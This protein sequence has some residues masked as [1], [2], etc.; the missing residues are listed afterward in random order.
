MIFRPR[1]PGQAQQSGSTSSQ[2]YSPV[3]GKDYFAQALAVNVE[4]SSSTSRNS[5]S[6]N[7]NESNGVTSTGSDKTANTASSFRVYYT[8]PSPIRQF[9]KHD[10]DDEN[11]ESPVVFVCHHGAGY[12]AMSFALLAEKI[13][14]AGQGVAGLLALDCRG[15]GGSPCQILFS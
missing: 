4:A 11:A 8:P 1:I 13:A 3:S 5:S 9:N 10:N 7:Q 6:N 15:H 12:S 14:S 2:V